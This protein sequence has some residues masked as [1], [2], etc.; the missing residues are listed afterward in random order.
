MKQYF[1]L[2][3]TGFIQVSLVS[4]NTYQIAHGHLVGVFVVGFLI[5]LVWSW[6]VKKIA[7]GSQIDRIVYATGAAFGTTAGLI[8][9]SMFY[10]NSIL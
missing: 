4:V 6:N 5:S 2:F 9:A 8:L 3:S 10:S 7:F 1:A